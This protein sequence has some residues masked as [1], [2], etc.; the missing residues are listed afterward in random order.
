M[1]VETPTWKYKLEG[2]KQTASEMTQLAQSV[3]TN[4]VELS[5]AKDGVA[6]LNNDVSG[7]DNRLTTIEESVANLADDDDLENIII[8]GAP[9]IIRNPHLLEQ[10]HLATLASCWFWDS[11]DL[12][13]LADKDDFKAITKRINGGYNGLSDRLMFLTRAKTELIK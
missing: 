7:L 13:D 8:N 2:D 4:A 10:P 1:A 5:N 12:N 11:R 6:N 3:I 9:D